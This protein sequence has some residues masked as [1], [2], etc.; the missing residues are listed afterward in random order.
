MGNKKPHL[1]G[2]LL[3]GTMCFSF[4]EISGGKNV[5]T[6]GTIET[7]IESQEITVS[8]RIEERDFLVTF[9]HEDIIFSPDPLTSS[10]PATVR[11][12]AIPI[13]VHAIQQRPP[14]MIKIPD[15]VLKVIAQHR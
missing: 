15:T 6:I 4:L 5:S 8:V 14:L 13:E 12:G 11:E 2:F 10:T 3:C 9:R 1:C 7:V